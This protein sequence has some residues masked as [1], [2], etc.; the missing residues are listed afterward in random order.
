MTTVKLSELNQSGVAK[1]DIDFTVQKVWSPAV[2]SK[3]IRARL[4]S[5]GAGGGLASAILYALTDYD[6]T[7]GPGMTGL[8]VLVNAIV[9]GYA[10]KDRPPD[11]P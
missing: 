1:K 2:S 11:S 3:A 6:I 10:H 5:A 4:L 7:V 8:I 9:F